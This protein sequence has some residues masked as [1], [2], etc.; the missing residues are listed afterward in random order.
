MPKITFVVDDKEYCTDADVGDTLLA[1][2]KKNNVPMFGGCDGA[3]VC[4]TCHV[5]IDKN[6]MTQTG[7]IEYAEDDLLDCLPKRTENSRLACQ[8]IVTDELDNAVVT[9]VR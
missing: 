3:C 8:V 5:T 9:V 1:V 4:G 2:A 6:H 7:D